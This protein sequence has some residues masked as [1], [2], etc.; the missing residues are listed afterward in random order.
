MG[1]AAEEPVHRSPQLVISVVGV[2]VLAVEEVR[3]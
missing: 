1:Q 3:R 2:A